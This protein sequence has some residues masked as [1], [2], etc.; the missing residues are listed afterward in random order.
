MLHGRALKTLA[1]R[2]RPESTST[3]TNSDRET[4]G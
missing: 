2:V 1:S 4:L 3:V